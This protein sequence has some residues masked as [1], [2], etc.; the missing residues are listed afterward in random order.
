MKNIMKLFVLV[1]AAAMALAS[2]QTQEMEDPTPTPK[3]YAYVFNIGDADDV[4]VP[5][6]SATLGYSC[7]EWETGDQ[8]GVY[9]DSQKGVSYNRWGDITPGSPAKFTISSYYALVAGDMVYCYYPY[10]SANSQGDSQDPRMVNLTIASNQTEKNQMPMVSLPYAVT[11]A[12]DEKADS[13]KSAGEIKLANLGSVIEFYVYSTT[14]VY[15]SELIQSV[16]FNAD[17]AIAGDFVFDLTAVDYSDEKTL[18]ISDYEATSVVSTLSAPVAV[19]AT[20]EEAKVVKMVVAPG[21]YTG[22]VVVTTDK[23]TYTYPISTAKEFKRSGVKPLGLDLRENVRQADVW[24]LVTSVDNMPDGEYVILAKHADAKEYGYLP[25]TTTSKAPVYTAQTVFDAVTPE[26]TDIAVDETMVWHFTESSGKWTIKNA[27]G[28]YFTCSNDNNGLRV[29]TTEDSWTI[30]SNSYN[31]AAFTMK[32]S[33][34]NR[35]VGV[36]N[37]QD[38]RSYTTMNAGNYGTAANGYQNAQLFFYYHGN[39]D[40]IPAISVSNVTGVSARGVEGATLT[41]VVVNPDGSEVVVACDGEIVTASEVVDGTIHYTVPANTGDATREGSITIT[42]GDV[43]KTIKVSQNAPEFKSSVTNREILLKADKAA[44]KSFTVTSDFDWTATLSEGAGFTVSPSGYVW[45]DDSDEEKGKQSVIVTAS[46]ANESPDGIV[47]L[48]TVTF[49][50]KTG[51][52][53][54]VTV[55]QESSYVDTSVSTAT[56]TFDDKSKRT[57]FSTTKQV[58]EENGITFTNDKASASSNVADYANPV[59]CYANSSITVEMAATMSVIEFTCG[60]SSYA[61]ALKNSIGN[62]ATSN[63]SVVTVN[64]A[65]PSTS[66]NVAKLTAQVQLKSIKV[67]YTDGTSGGETP[68]P[69]TEEPEQSLP[70]LIATAPDQVSA[71]GGSASISYSVTNPVDGVSV[72]AKTNVSWIT[73]FTYTDNNVIFN[74]AENKGNAREADVTLEYTGATSVIVKV[75]QAASQSS[76]SG[77]YTV[78]KTVSDLSAGTYLMG[79]NN[80]EKYSDGTMYIWSDASSVSGQKLKTAQATYE[81]GDFTTDVSSYVNIE[82]IAA[83]SDN[84]YYIKVNGKYLKGASKVWSLVDSPIAWTFADM[85]GSKE[86]MYFYNTDNTSYVFINSTSEAIR[87]YAN[88]TKYKGIYLFKKN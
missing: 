21:S 67:T 83:G 64:L 36:Y 50:S 38:W 33:N 9:T 77:G 65:N 27:A 28:N 34:Q 70:E 45:E 3:E 18:A 76:V 37:N 35:Y 52:E 16:T 13:E 6:T 20:K 40:A 60:S 55:K 66:F 58:W 10:N 22:K 86:G 42:Y 7:V 2:C 72:T 14:P 53:F 61:T 51:Q 30:T 54:I 87:T 46:S 47:V 29:N 43:V 69:D 44:D 71:L 68:G 59:R 25:T 8:V 75:S 78:I 24:S 56:L 12:L 73:D 39:L 23:A 19:P 17:K 85:G 41:F 1:A 84:V 49:T 80:A 4:D 5:E 32:S 11:E 62:D 15:Q 31:N 63:G 88:S 48:G 74:V 26:Y 57:S 81:N 82:L 79:G